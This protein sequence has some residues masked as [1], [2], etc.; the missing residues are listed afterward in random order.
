LGEIQP[1]DFTE[2][3]V[4]FQIGV[5]PVRIDIMITVPGLDFQG[6][7][8]RRITV[9]FGGETEPVLCREDVD[10][11]KRTGEPATRPQRSAE[12]GSPPQMTSAR[13]ARYD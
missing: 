3:N 6:S 4:F 7:W 5:E 12:I 10:R 9:D 1:A 2:P 8:K 11:A 13:D